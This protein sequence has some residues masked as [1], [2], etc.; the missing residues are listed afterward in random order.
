MVKTFKYI[1]K[2]I[3]IGVGI[4]LVLYF[5]RDLLC[6]QV[7]AESRVIYP[8]S[9]SLKIYRNTGSSYNAT[10]TTFSVSQYG[11]VVWY[12]VNSTLTPNFVW[13]LATMDFDIARLTKK[14]YYDFDFMVITGYSSE[15][16]D[17]Y[18]FSIYTNGGYNVCTSNDSN[19]VNDD[20]LINSPKVILNVSCTNIYIDIE[21]STD[22][23]L[24]AYMGQST[25]FN[26]LFGT[27]VL[28]SNFLPNNANNQL[29][30]AATETNDLL[31]DDSSP[32]NDS[33]GGVLN[34]DNMQKESNSPVSDLIT[35][36]ITFLSSIN[37]NINGSCT[38][39]NL[40]S[41]LG[42]DI[43][44]P[45]IDLPNILGS[46]LYNL[47]DMAICLFLA[48]NIGKLCITIYN[49]LTTLKDDYSYMYSSEGY[50]NQ[51]GESD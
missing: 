15:L 10:Q 16:L 3:L 11:S 2:R 18:T 19:V 6:L 42:H 34:N 43:T 37:N 44:L 12:G 7:N 24:Y 51:K 27:T 26:E 9:N 1:I 35:M 5:C 28:N 48:F 8:K 20:Q 23:K 17:D 47:I 31:K 46:T 50:K 13:S 25:R 49:N 21:Q 14:G 36:P 33:V 32:S 39:W 41:L 38:T 40:G 45:C 22:F 30:A 29:V 4:A